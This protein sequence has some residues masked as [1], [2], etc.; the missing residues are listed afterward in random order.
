MPQ[1]NLSSYDTTPISVGPWGG[2]SGEAWNDG[3]YSGIRQ[4]IIIHGIGIDS[5]QFEYDVNG[6]SKWSAKHGGNDGSKTD[7]VKLKNS[8]RKQLF[9]L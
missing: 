4:L 1:Q 5:I 9:F 6:S 7:K 2:Q 3:I 8:E